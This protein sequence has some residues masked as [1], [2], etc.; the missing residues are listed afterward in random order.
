MDMDMDI[1]ICFR[2]TEFFPPKSLL[3]FHTT[4]LFFRY[5]RASPH[6]PQQSV[7]S[8]TTMN[9]LTLDDHKCIEILHRHGVDSHKLEKLLDQSVNQAD[10]VLAQYDEYA[11]GGDAERMPAQLAK[12]FLSG[13]FS[14][15]V[16]HLNETELRALHIPPLEILV[17]NPETPDWQKYDWSLGEGNGIKSRLA[18]VVKMQS[19]AKKNLD[20]TRNTLQ[21]YA[22]CILES[23]GNSIKETG[24][25][26]NDL[27]SS[28]D[29]SLMK[30]VADLV[31]YLQPKG[32]LAEKK[33]QPQSKRYPHLSDHHDPLFMIPLLHDAKIA[34]ERLDAFISD[35]MK[36]LP[37]GVEQ[38]RA[39]LKSLER[40]MV[41]VYEKYRCNFSMLTDL[42]RSTIV[43]DNVEAL[44]R[45]LV[46]LKAAVDSNLATIVRIK[47]RL[48]KSFDAMEAGGYRDILMNMYFPP[49]D[50]N[51]SEHLVELQLNLK[52]FVKIKDGGGHGSYAVA[53]MLQAFDPALVSYTG[54]I[55]NES[56]RDIRTGLTKK[57]T[58]LGVIV[59]AK[60]EA[61]L[62]LQEPKRKNLFN[63]LRGP[64]E[65][66]LQ[67]Q[68]ENELKQKEYELKQAEYTIDKAAAEFTMA[69]SLASSTVQLVEFKL[70]NIKF[71]GT[72]GNCDWLR[73]AAEH[74]AP[75]LQILVIEE[76]GVEGSIPSEVGL[77][78]HLNVLNLS[79]NK[80]TGTPF[81]FP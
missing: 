64:T 2:D 50:E 74:L 66:E 42:A 40:A 26:Y 18:S 79:E 67:Q 15:T 78:R 48:D 77:L 27:F 9:S 60:L 25:A 81:P 58:L 63:Q 17:N 53:R 62:L 13:V 5:S 47:F 22:P 14:G 28:L 70:L 45:V 19:I 6:R 46:E 56:S 37:H 32:G 59:D 24:S 3:H 39:P 10:T 69:Q 38:K 36:R 1:G 71:N 80:L 54:M 57:A 20:E 43:C 61:G 68:K 55:N 73:A 21:K 75:C 30:D 31:D 41:K 23:V 44:K 65:K 29:Q 34:K 8:S 33:L 49:K 4:I 16:A 76:C 51:E 72:L 52:E 11:K 7:F 35:I 12:A